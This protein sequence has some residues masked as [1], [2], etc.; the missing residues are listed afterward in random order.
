MLIDKGYNLVQ[1]HLEI[2]KILKTNSQS[3]I[4]VKTKMKN[5]PHLQI[6]VEEEF[7]V[8]IYK[9]ADN[10]NHDQTSEEV[11]EQEFRKL[12]NSL[13]FDSRIPNENEVRG[14]KNHLNTLYELQKMTIRNS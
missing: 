8:D 11:I 10:P 13:T 7:T 5:K 3:N 1:Q 12:D 14:S 2:S 4:Y 9:E 6:Q